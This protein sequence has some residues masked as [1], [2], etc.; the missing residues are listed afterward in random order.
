MS[1][2]QYN[3]ES[4]SHTYQLLLM[5]TAADVCAVRFR[6]GESLDPAEQEWLVWEINQHLAEVKGRAPSLED[7]PEADKPEV[8]V[9]SAES[10]STSI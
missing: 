1:S 5:S 10:S 4:H 9:H 2:V 3:N 6:F 8:C 7:M